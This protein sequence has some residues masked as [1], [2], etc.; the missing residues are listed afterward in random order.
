[1]RYVVLGILL[2]VALSGC[3]RDPRETFESSAW[4]DPGPFAFSQSVR[5]AFNQGG[6]K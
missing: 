1:M 3:G 6:I 5:N 4:K 2:V